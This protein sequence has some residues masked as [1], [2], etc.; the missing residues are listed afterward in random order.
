MAKVDYSD[1]QVLLIESSGN[2]RSTIFYMLRSLGVVNLKAV[3]INDRVITE[4]SENNYDVILLG[5]NV[6]DSVTGIQI[7]EEC[8]YRDFIKPSAC[9]IFMTSDASQEI[10]LHAID[11]RP[12]DLIM[13]P[14]SVDELKHRLDS[15]LYRK[16][17]FKPV[18]EALEIGDLP[19]AINFCKRNFSTYD[20]EYAES[21]LILAKL[22][23]QFQKFDESIGVAEQIYW[24]SHDKEAGL[25][26]AE[27][28]VAK[29]SYSA[30]RNTLIDLIEEYPLYMAAYD[31][32]A[33]V[34]EKEGD[35][36]KAR[37]T[38]VEATQKCPMGIPR[39]MELGRLATQ[40]KQLDV[41][42]GAYK[43][44][45]V[46]GRHSCYR[47]PEP[48]LRFANVKRLE[49]N[50]AL[51]GVAKELEGEF[52]KTLAQAFQAFPN[53]RVLQVKAS[54]LKSEMYQQLGETDAANRA[55]REAQ[56][57][58]SE[59]DAPLDL[60]RE[61]LSVTGDAVPILEPEDSSVEGASRGK[62]VDPE[63]SG[64]VNRLGVK[65][66]LSGK[67]P[68]ALKYFGLATEYDASNASALLNLAQ[69]F[70][71]SA[72]DSVD[73]REERLKMVRRYMKLSERLSLDIHEKSKQSELKRYL[74]HE[75]DQL[76][77]G[78]LGNLLR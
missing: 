72:R 6:S 69:L 22:L 15:I 63:M 50:G 42:G 52:E 59:L 46:L 45:I 68:Q 51:G 31:L 30:A 73:K 58:N 38:A 23:L 7:L 54:L 27:G 74:E 75:I 12:D 55:T 3:T 4:V 64:K 44:S 43:K 11:S 76:P 62:K 14:F 57:I 66:Y 60:D 1:K 41:A 28:L 34:F 19:A 29:G 49:M 78:G 40:T 37:D 13:K 35:L 39:Q 32:L 16:S 33:I 47:S 26:W 10:V 70:L 2:M 36:D 56:L 20:P 67:I 17:V 65:H 71:E 8:R 24:N 48:Y 61:L 5:H 25:I 21:Q 18:D 77:H 9:W 53:D